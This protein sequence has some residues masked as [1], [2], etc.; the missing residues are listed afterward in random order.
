MLAHCKVRGVN[1][2]LLLPL[3]LLYNYMIYLAI[4]DY[5]QGWTCCGQFCFLNLAWTMYLPQEKKCVFSSFFFPVRLWGKNRR[6]KG[7]H[8]GKLKF[9]AYISGWKILENHLMEELMSVPSPKVK[10][11]SSCKT[12]SA[13]ST[14]KVVFG[15]E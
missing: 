1:K 14:E 12:F 5:S 10:Q 13:C 15:T 9:V 6:R 3:L 7:F 8:D 2:V 11:S 4:M